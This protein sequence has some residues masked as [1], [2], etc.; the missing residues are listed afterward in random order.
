MVA[1]AKMFYSMEEAAEKLGVDVDQLKSMADSGKLQQFRDRDKVMFKVDQVD[2][3]AAAGSSSTGEPALSDSDSGSIPMADAA[4]DTDAIDLGAAIDADHEKPKKPED[5]RGATGISVFDADEIDAVDPLAQTVVSGSVTADDDELALESVGSGSGLLDLTR[6]SDDTSLGAELLEEIYPA[7][8]S[9]AKVEGGSGFEGI[10]D[11][12]GGVESAPSGLTDVD[13]GNVAADAAPGGA[14]MVMA[15]ASDPA[16]SGWT[17][18][19]L[20]GG[21][22]ALVIGVMVV[23]ASMLGTISGLATSMAEDLP[24]YAGALLG[25]SVVLA[26]IGGFLGKAIGR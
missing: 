18:G 15:E 25:V 7:G 13:P 17:A 9:D 20:I 16:G 22:A 12:A 8:G 3:L 5:A 23:L 1:M 4:G 26:I 19:M 24:M 10:F 6:E 21:I 11:A 2:Q 14:T